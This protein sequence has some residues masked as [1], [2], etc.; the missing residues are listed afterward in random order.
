VSSPD[1]AAAAA[2]AIGF[3][4]VLKTDEP[5][6][7]HKSEVGGVVLGVTTP[8]AASAAFG[9]LATRLGPRILVSASAREGV[10][11]ALGVVRDPQLGLLMVVGAGG[12][13]VE[14]LADRVVRLPPMDEAQAREDLGRLRA[15]AL[16]DGVRGAEP[17]DREAVAH[18]VVAL[19]TLSI[20]LGDVLQALDVNPLRCGPW[21][22]LALD[23]LL[24][25]RHDGTG[26]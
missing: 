4:V 1:E 11:L 21:G 2:D 12:V 9:D 23:V 7:S 8:A 19:S 5:S 24:E 22:C 26:P 15:S 10:E 25:V 20:E 18:A 14:V 6:I 13:L 16:L 17:V 3:P